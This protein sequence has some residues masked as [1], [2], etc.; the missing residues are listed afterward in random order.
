MA[1]KKVVKKNVEKKKTK[2][3][4]ATKKTQK[5][6]EIKNTTKEKKLKKASSNLETK[7]QSQK[8]KST[9]I[10]DR[11]MKKKETNQKKETKKTLATKSNSK[12]KQKENHLKTKSGQEKSKSIKRVEEDYLLD[13]LI[14][15]KKEILED[16]DEVTEVE[17]IDL[18]NIE[19]VITDEEPILEDEEEYVPKT[20]GRKK[21]VQQETS[22]QQTMEEIIRN[23]PLQIDPTKKTYVSPKKDEPQPY[24]APSKSNKERYSDKELQEFKEIILQRLKETQENYNQLKK[25]FTNEDG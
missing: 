16:D 17:E 4:K 18:S 2:N 12:T 5:K 8:Q 23:R 1:K 14:V 15:N 11:T 24:I 19:P 9:K 10:K 13:D 22:H 3:T 20:R 21:Q 25:Y 6:A 7:S